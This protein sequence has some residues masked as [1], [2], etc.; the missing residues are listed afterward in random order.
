MIQPT[1]KKQNAESEEALLFWKE[2]FRERNMDREVFE[3]ITEQ[4]EMILSV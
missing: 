2:D 4:Q 3:D 1:Q